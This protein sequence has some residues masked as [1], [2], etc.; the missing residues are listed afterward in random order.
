MRS[1]N[2][3]KLRTPEHTCPGTS[4]NGYLYNYSRPWVT[5]FRIQHTHN[6]PKTLWRLYGPFVLDEV[7]YE[8]NVAS[9]WGLLSAPR[10][11]QRFW[12]GATAGA[13]G[14][15]GEV[16]NIEPSAHCGG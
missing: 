2:W 13:Y 14:G 10:M 9:N 11:V 12:W 16:L 7:K 3:F 5:H 4:N 8:G 15:Y 1:S 6:K